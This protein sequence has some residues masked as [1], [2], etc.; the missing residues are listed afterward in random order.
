MSAALSASIRPSSEFSLG[1]A[2]PGIAPE[3]VAGA[4]NGV[5]TVLLSQGFAPVVAC[6][7]E[8]FDFEPHEADSSY[9]AFYECAKEA[10]ERLLGVAPNFSHN[11]SW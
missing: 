10:T 4:K 7:V 6:S 1:V 2:A 11:I 3:Y 5:V 8:L 9:A